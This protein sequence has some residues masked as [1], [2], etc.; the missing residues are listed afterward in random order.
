MDESDQAV[1]LSILAH[2]NTLPHIKSCMAVIATRELSIIE[3]I[4]LTQ[5]RPKHRVA[6]TYS[7]IRTEA[8]KWL[9][10]AYS[11][12]SVPWLNSVNTQRAGQL[13]DCMDAYGVRGGVHAGAYTD[14]KM[15]LHASGE[16]GRSGGFDFWKAVEE[17][18]L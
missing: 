17:V 6:P 9:H 10:D 3:I 15:S 18:D 4:R 14:A 11:T 16:E 2:K 8:I 12:E 5:E 1:T 13:V 7:R